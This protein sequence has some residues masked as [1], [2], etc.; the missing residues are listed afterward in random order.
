MISHS[1]VQRVLDVKAGLGEAPIWSVNHRALFW[2]DID[3][4]TINRFTPASGENRVWMM[5]ATPGCFALC[6]ENAAVVAA[7]DGFYHINF[8]SGEISKLCP[9]PFNAKT[10]R[11]NDGKT[12]RQGR[13]WVSSFLVDYMTSRVDDQGIVY[14]FDG[15]K[16]D[17][18]IVPVT[19]PNGIA[20]SPDGKTLYRNESLRRLIYAHDY[21]PRTGTVSRQRTFAEIPEEYGFPDGA[22]VDGKGG[23]WVALP[24]GS[25]TGGVGR[26]TPEGKLDIYIAVPVLMP[27]MVAFGGPKMSTLYITSAGTKEIYPLPLGEMAGDIFAVETSFQGIEETKFSAQG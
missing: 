16:I 21:D 3:K 26:F 1:S 19:V 7:R 15:A 20:F 12:D 18:G 14:R 27:T 9:A 5:P 2:V 23:Y 25:K 10:H 6:D 22:T 11:F 24:A 17:A 8:L 4:S 13:F